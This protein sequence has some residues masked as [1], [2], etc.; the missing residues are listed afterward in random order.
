MSTRPVT[1]KRIHRSPAPLAANATR[2]SGVA[3]IL[4]IL[5]LFLLA[6]LAVSALDTTMKDAQI[7]GAKKSSEASLQMAEAGVADALDFLY[8]SYNP[9]N[10]PEV[11]ET[12]DVSLYGGFGGSFAALG[13]HSTDVGT[14]G[15]A[16][17]TNISMI[18]LGEGCMTADPSHHYGVWDIEIEGGVG[19]GRSQSTIHIGA[20]MCQCTDILGC[21]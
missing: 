6:T 15:L 8:N 17:G 9:V 2:E 12:I 1:T 16:S 4:T 21:D 18:G 20:L 13:S 14:F 3:L 11:G 10:L 5:M 19:G 7:V